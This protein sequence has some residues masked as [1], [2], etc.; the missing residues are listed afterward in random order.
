MESRR[1]GSYDYGDVAKY[2]GKLIQK[3]VVDPDLREWIM[4]GFTTT[5]EQDEVVA[6]ILMMGAMQK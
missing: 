3:S 5:T 2:M 6:S 1:R 4:P